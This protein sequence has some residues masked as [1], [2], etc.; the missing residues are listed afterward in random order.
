MKLADAEHTLH[1]HLSFQGLDIAVENRKGS[2][3]KGVDK[4]GKAW[5]T[6]MKL[7]YGYLVGSKGADGDGV[8]VYIGPDK[9]APNAY[10]VHQ[11]KDDGSYDEDKVIL[12]VD[13]EEE[14]RKW[15]LAHYNTDKYLGPIK[16]VPLERLKELLASDKKLT[17]ISAISLSAFLEELGK[18]QESL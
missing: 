14:A 9:K 2:V 7:P 16:E 10:V 3:R 13:S 18:M 8:D 17:K 12:G 1:G 6:V 11:K 5:R 15:Y 4:D